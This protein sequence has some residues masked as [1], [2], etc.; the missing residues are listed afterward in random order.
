VHLYGV[1]LRFR[2]RQ[3]ETLESAISHGLHCWFHT[4]FTHSGWDMHLRLRLPSSA[5]TYSHLASS[6]RTATAIVEGETD[7]GT[8]KSAGECPAVKY[9]VSMYEDFYT[10][11]LKIGFTALTIASEAVYLNE[12]DELA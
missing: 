11:L 9:S 8:R 1:S 5:L 12:E 2:Q 4:T 10:A 6:W 3:A 7:F